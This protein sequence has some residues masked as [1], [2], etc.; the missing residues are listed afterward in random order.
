MSKSTQA[1]YSLKPS[2]PFVIQ[3]LIISLLT[4]LGL[5]AIIYFF[6]IPLFENTSNPTLIEKIVWASFVFLSFVIFAL[7]Y[8][9]INSIRYWIDYNHLEVIN[10]LRPKKRRMIP[11]EQITNFRIIQMPF[12][13]KQF[14]YGTIVL[15]GKEP[16]EQSK[17][18]ARLW[19]IRFPEEVIQDLAQ[20]IKN[21]ELKEDQIIQQYLK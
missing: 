7:I 21:V 20:N 14:D 13:G 8:I 9:L 19:G 15:E 1:R 4:N 3:W 5:F 16:D 11:F 12:F 18:L 2:N 6:I 17:I 10:N